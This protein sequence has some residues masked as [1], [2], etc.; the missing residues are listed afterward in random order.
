MS[1]I[2]KLTPAVHVPAARGNLYRA[3]IVGAASLKEKK[4]RRC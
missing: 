4:L 2:A 1:D 3:A